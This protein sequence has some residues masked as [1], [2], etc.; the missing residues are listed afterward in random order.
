[1]SRDF[2]ETDA[3]MWANAVQALAAPTHWEALIAAAIM[4]D[5]LED[6]LEAS[7][8]GAVYDWILGSEWRTGI[9]IQDAA[10]MWEG[11]WIEQET[12]ALFGERGA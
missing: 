7:Y 9:T 6:H 1:M 4:E 8:E 3:Q 12:D 5:M 10:A 2:D 11:H